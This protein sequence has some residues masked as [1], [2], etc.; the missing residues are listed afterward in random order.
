[1]LTLLTTIL[2]LLAVVTGCATRREIRGQ[3]VDGL[4]RKLSTFAYIEDGDLVDFIVATKATRYRDGEPYV[5][6]EVGVANRGLKQL[7]L[8]R[9]SFVLIDAEGNRYPAAG[10]SELMQSYEFLDL[11]QRLLELRGVVDTKYAAM[12][13]YPSKFSPTRAASSRRSNL[14]RDTVSLP[15]FGYMLDILYFPAPSTGVKD[16]RF[17]LFLQA[18]ELPDPVF[19]KFEVK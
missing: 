12:T 10:P 9:E 17:E 15:R 7:T 5:P 11:D 3:A 2:V 8:S 14:V 19:V 18:P 16:Q 1:M 6:I 13:P 4:D